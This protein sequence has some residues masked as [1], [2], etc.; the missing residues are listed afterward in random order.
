KRQLFSY[1]TDYLVI[2]ISVAAFGALDRA[3]PHHQ[4][5]SLKDINI[6]YPY[7]LDERVSA[8]QAG[9]I[10]VLFPL[11]VLVLWTLAVEGR[12]PLPA[13]RRLRFI[14]RLW[15]LN[16]AILSLGLA[17]GIALVATNALKNTVGRPRPDLLSRCV[18]RA[19]SADASPFGLSTSE[20]C[21]QT[22]AAVLRDGFKSFPSGH[23]SISF[24]GLGLLAFWLAGKLRLMDGRGHIWK[25]VVVMIPIAA[26]T[27]VAVSRIM[28]KRHHA[29]DVL[30]GSALG[31][32]CAWVAYRQYFPSL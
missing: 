18:V 32:I 4:P 6:Q 10:A 29:F 12:L 13:K 9:V 11:V 3:D 7:A 5:F 24:S 2:F 21:T 14:E 31:I 22:D 27:L 19:D 17:V 28:D 15:E 1:I 8:A 25:V 30:F 26:A 20:I 16:L 23:S